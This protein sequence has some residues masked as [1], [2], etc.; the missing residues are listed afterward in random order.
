MHL[1]LTVRESP[2][3]TLRMYSE[4]TRPSLLVSVRDPSDLHAWRQFEARYREL[5]VRYCLRRGLQAADYEDVQQLVWLHLAKGLRNFEYDPNKGRFRDYLGRVVRNAI[6]RHFARPNRQVS[7]LDSS[8]LAVIPSETDSG[9]DELWEQEW[10]DHHY[11]RA[12][13]AIRETFDPKSVSVFEGLIRGQGVSDAAAA[14][15]MTTEA[16]H[17]VKQRIRLRLSELIAQQIAEEDAT[18]A[19][20]TDGKQSSV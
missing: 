16:V 11:R 15:S 4:S 17:K 3:G 14:Y 2:H 9:T 1:G 13:A 18:D 10:V 8:L 6:S 12:M 7:A 20:S 19:Q 5:I